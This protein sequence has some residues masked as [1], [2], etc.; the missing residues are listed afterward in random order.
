MSRL[1][2]VISE[3]KADCMAS[4]GMSKPL[5]T[6][7][8]AFLIAFAAFVVAAVRARQPRPAAGRG[9]Q[10]G[11]P[12]G[13]PAAP[14]PLGQPLLDPHGFVKD[15]AMLHPPALAAEDRKYADIDGRRMKQV[16]ME[17]D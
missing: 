14:N 7:V 6:Q 12:G 9:G 15:E 11:E 17:V 3:R 2:R 16:V 8:L 1:W 10:T 5:A 4:R 13:G